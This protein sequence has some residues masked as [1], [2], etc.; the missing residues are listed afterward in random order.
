[1]LILIGSIY[2]SL[3]Y[4]KNFE[5]ASKIITVVLILCGIWLLFQLSLIGT[6]QY[7]YSNVVKDYSTTYTGFLVE[8]SND[9]LNA[10]WNLTQ[11]YYTGFD[12][13]YNITSAYIPSRNFFY[14]PYTIPVFIE[15][16]QNSMSGFQRLLVTQQK[17]NCGEFSQSIVYL[18]NDTTHFPTRLIYFEGIDHM[19]PEVYITNQWW[20]FDIDY[21]TP[22]KPIDSYNFSKNIPDGVREDIAYIHSSQNQQKSLL[23]QHGFNETNITI[24]ACLDMPATSWDGKPIQGVKIE[25]FS[26]NNSHDPLVS[27]GITDENGEYSTIINPE[28][29]YRIFATYESNSQKLVGFASVSKIVSDNLSINV[30]ITNYG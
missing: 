1:M 26:L 29:D 4:L 10:S 9:T 12:G 27:Q 16:Y 13:T 15:C 7:Q 23:K 8:N 18:L 2:I 17:G 5:N 25:V 19:M 6:L 30:K 11:K 28:K 24:T 21:L 22:N 14:F 20:V 3:K